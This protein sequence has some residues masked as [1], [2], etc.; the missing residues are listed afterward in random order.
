MQEEL[1]IRSAI[2]NSKY[3]VP[4]PI[5]WEAASLL[6][7]Q[8]SSEQVK[9]LFPGIDNSISRIKQLMGDGYF[10]SYFRRLDGIHKGE[11]N[12]SKK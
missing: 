2:P 5:I 6:H 10:D 1:P 4:R 11:Y 8:Y 9:E 7:K 3:E 12:D